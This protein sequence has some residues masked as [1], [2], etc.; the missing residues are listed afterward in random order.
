MPKIAVF[1]TGSMTVWI[2]PEHKTVHHVIHKFVYG[3]EL[4]NGLRA[5]YE[6]FKKHQATKWLSDDRKNGALPA[7]D[8]E[9]SKSDWFP[10][11]VQAGWKSW[12]M[13]PPQT[14]IGKMNIKRLIQ[15][16]AAAGITAQIFATPDE[17]RK[18]LDAQ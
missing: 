12:A 17:A 1:D 10:K 13:V 16:Y 9:W 11:M 14:V 3:E 15:E 2:Q 5:G 7:E 18:W 4:R 8:V 6:A